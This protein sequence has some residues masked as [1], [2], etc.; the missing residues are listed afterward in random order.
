MA[1]AKQFVVVVKN[2]DKYNPRKD[3]TNPSW[4]R[5]QHNFFTSSQ[6]F[7]FDA[8]DVR[9]WLYILCEASLRNQAG[10]VTV[11]SD[12]ADRVAQI[13]QK[14]LHR[15]LEKLKEKQIVEVRTL[16]GRYADVTPTFAYNE[17]NET[18]ERNETRRDE[19]D[20]QGKGGKS[21]AKALPLLAQIWN[22]FSESLPKVT[23]CGKP[24]KKSAEERWDEI[25][26]PAYWESVVRRIAAS[27]FCRGANDRGWKAD[28]DFL[29]K[30][31][32]AARVLE[33]KYDPRNP[34]KVVTG[35]FQRNESLDQ[36][37]GDLFGEVK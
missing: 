24:R 33:G 35:A 29:I 31:D 12:H 2:W 14:Q 11:N 13:P 1:A 26:D 22:E 27:P 4:F 7:D 5:F 36:A 32:T 3:V 25:P 6:F 9:A 18:D 21:S 17:T 10:S 28:F 15:T 23:T 8:E 20:E 34:S 30:P 37:F 16:R 19:A